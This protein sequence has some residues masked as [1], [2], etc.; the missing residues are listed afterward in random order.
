MIRVG[1]SP[2]KLNEM[3]YHC[4]FAR[5]LV[6]AAFLV[7]ATFAPAQ[8]TLIKDSQIEELA[9]GLWRIRLG[10]P[11]KLTPTFFRSA[12]VAENA[13][14]TL[15]AGKP[16]FSLASIRFSVNGRG[17]SVQLPLGK[18]E[19][20]FGCGLNT[21]LFNLT[22][23][24]LWIRTSDD[25]ESEL[26]DSHA[27]VPFYVT[28]AGYGI[29]VD[30]ARYVSFYT[31][32]A[33]PS[34]LMPSA[35]AARTDATSTEELYRQRELNAK[36]VL[37]DVPAAKGVD[38]YVF[39]GPTMKE[40]VQRYNLFS[41]GGCLPPIWGLG[42]WYRGKTEFGPRD[43]LKLSQSFRED[44][45][46]CDVW[47]LE[48]G[49]QSHAYPCSFAW[50]NERFPDPDGF[51]KQM[52]AA[53][54]H[55]NAWE[56]VFVHSSS[57]IYKALAALSGD[58]LVWNGL[59]PD[60]SLPE[61]RSI[62]ATQQNK[63]LFEKG[64]ETVKLDECDNQPVSAKPWSFPE[65][66]TFPS[67]LDGEQMHGLLGVLYQQTM[68]ET[69]K[70][71]NRRS[72]NSVRAS[73]ALAAPLPFVLYSDSYDHRAYVRGIAKSGFSGLLWAPELRDARSIE[74]LYRR[75]ETIVFSAQTLVNCWY[76]KNPPWLQ[77]NTDKSNRGELMPERAE[78]TAVV[79]R[80]F[81]L[82]MS[83]IPYLYSA[84]AE[85]QANGTAPFRA[86][87]MD[88]PHDTN[89]WQ[90]DDEYLVGPSLLVA[91]IFADQKS[92][93]VYLPEGEWFD[94]WTGE[95]LPGGRKMDV[96]KPV[97]QIPVY[98]KSGT[99]LPLAKPVECVKPGTC[100]DLTVRVYGSHPA[101]LPLYEDDGVSYDYEKGMQNKIILSWSPEKGGQIEKSGNYPGPDRY[102]V[103]AWKPLDGR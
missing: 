17:C 58:Y 70:K 8:S 21:R 46:P 89:T 50:N 61:A 69:P 16:P 39:G 52:R 7:F 30:S 68:W 13:L 44:H 82:R 94:F 34:A 20:V 76:M 86:V 19:Q 56:H 75:V 11:E 18:D 77:I 1:G 83:L 6:A 84:F 5:R 79:R 33:E 101:A 60:L 49:W 96:T 9:P 97:D 42:V 23:R 100:F 35:R 87:V 27:P 88:Y 95:R 4:R 24:R 41:G 71:N 22:N 80:L 43:C 36:I 98:V 3:N 81:E 57:P 78:V 67:G 54:F 72:Y 47:G 26:N 29:F 93:A 85:Y 99:L 90:L 37:A 103:E 25:P 48:P 66:S 74:D 45:I 91:P 15:S 55:L 51:I 65:C 38:V 63:V 73:H 12:P 28:T 40:A 62:F 64:V 31:G 14:K 2:N 59:V 32:I 102:K 53:D 10:S 92:R